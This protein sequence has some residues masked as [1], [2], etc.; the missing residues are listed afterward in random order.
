MDPVSELLN[1]NYAVY[2]EQLCDYLNN[3]VCIV[4]EQPRWYW[5][6]EFGDSDL[7]WQGTGHE[8]SD[9]VEQKNT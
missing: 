4:C 9:G 3:V 1:I 6:L 7:T 2:Q 5:R 8:T